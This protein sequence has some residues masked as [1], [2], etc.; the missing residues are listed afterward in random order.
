MRLPAGTRDWLPPELQRKRAVE[1]VL[2]GVFQRWAYAEVQTPSF[3]RFDALELGLGDGVAQKTFL[4]ND[5][6]G[7]QLALR[8][9]MTTP[10]AR[11]VSTRMRG[12]PLPIRLSYVQ[13]AYRYEEPQE[14]RMREFTQAGLELIGSSGADADAES[15]F[16]AL[17]A[18][19][20][21]G[22]SDARFDLN[23]AAIIDGVLN[24]VAWE[25]AQLATCKRL[26]AGRNIVALREFLSATGHAE[27]A[28]DLVGLV[29]LRGREDV[30]QRASERCSTAEGREGIG[31]LREILARAD[32]LGFGERLAVDLSLLR[33]VSYYTGFIFEGFASEVGFA[34]CGGG[35]YDSL[36]PRFGFEA[37]AV[38]WSVNVERLLIALER[39]HSSQ[40]G[41]APAVDVLVS[42]SDVLAAR[43]R[44]AGKIVRIDFESRSESELLSAARAA[45]IPRVLIARGGDV[46]ELE[47]TW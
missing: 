26:I 13:S 32:R 35:R 25:P 24:N 44:A 27:A 38:G 31:R 36:L 47:V 22:L 39:R 30:L 6:G 1:A 12:A 34:L 23:H 28:G 5:R 21:L 45:R 16:T 2:R 10:V 4:F 19:D 37:G 14:G 8:P 9:E 29:M 42:G 11:L 20:A 3:E 41:D 15:L 18:L 40:F 33:D 17:E 7:T 46:S 43:E